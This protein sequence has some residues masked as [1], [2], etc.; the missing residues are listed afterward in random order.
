MSA[1]SQERYSRFNGAPAAA[2]GI[3]QTPGSNAVE[4]ARQ[5]R[6][7]MSTLADAL[8][9]RSRLYGRSGTPRSSSRRRSMR[10]FER[11]S[12]RS[13]SWRGG[14]L[15]PRQVANDADPARCRA[16]VDYR[17]LRRDAGHRLFGQYRLAAGPRACHRH[18][19]RRCHRG[20]RECRA[21]DGGKPRSCRCRRPARRRWRRL[22]ARSSPSRSSCCRCSSRSPSSLASAGSS[23]ANSRWPSRCRC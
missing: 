22:P 6:E 18:R 16:G 8:S 1:K 3:Y 15:V 2:I 4:V 23:S 5:V 9:R 14:V 7:T 20:G 17:H 11:S 19:G 10:S 12:W 13:Y 21:G